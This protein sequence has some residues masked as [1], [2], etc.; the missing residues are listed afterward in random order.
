MDTYHQA[1]WTIIYNAVDL[2]LLLDKSRR[3]PR[4]WPLLYALLEFISTVLTA[5]AGVFTVLS[6]FLLVFNGNYSRVLVAAAMNFI[7]RY[8]APNSL[9]FK[10][11]AVSNPCPSVMHFILFI[12]LG[13]CCGLARDKSSDPLLNR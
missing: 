1:G 3:F 6:G 7:L 11:G 5:A 12:W 8:V 9:P 2:F 10:T 4:P 13:D